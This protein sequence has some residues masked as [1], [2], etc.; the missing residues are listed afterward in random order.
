ML[1]SLNFPGGISRDQFQQRI[2]RQMAGE[3]FWQKTLAQ[4]RI[5]TSCC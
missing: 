5:R 2:A 3:R 1:K 4:Q